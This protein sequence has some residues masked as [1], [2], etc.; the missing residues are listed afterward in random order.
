LSALTDFG[1]LPLKTA[2]KLPAWGPAEFFSAVGTGKTIQLADAYVARFGVR[3][4][5]V[6]AVVVALGARAKKPQKGNDEN[7]LG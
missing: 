1:H 2:L 7:G 4:A 3:A 6:C 5:R